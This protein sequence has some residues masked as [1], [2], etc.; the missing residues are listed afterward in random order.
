MKVYSHGIKRCLGTL[1]KH[2]VYLLQN[3]LG[4]SGNSFEWFKESSVFTRILRAVNKSNS[5]SDSVC[6]QNF[7]QSRVIFSADIAT[8]NN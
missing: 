4:L 3:N 2:L 6:P 7:N 8:E 1:F 5:D